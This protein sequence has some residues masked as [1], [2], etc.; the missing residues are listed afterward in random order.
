MLS[1]VEML[2]IL[3]LFLKCRQSTSA[4]PPLPQTNLNV[5]SVPL[6]KIFMDFQGD[7]IRETEEGVYITHPSKYLR[8]SFDIFLLILFSVLPLK[9]LMC[10]PREALVFHF[11]YFQEPL[12]LSPC[13]SSW[14][15]F[16]FELAHPTQLTQRAALIQLILLKCRLTL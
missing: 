16:T 7:F 11:I 15:N 1:S 5:V 6:Q 8:S 14:P 4:A 12:S 13:L 10:L 9:L 3:L 2:I